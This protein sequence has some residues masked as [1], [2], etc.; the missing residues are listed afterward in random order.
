MWTFNR[1]VRTNRLLL[2]WRFLLRTSLF[3]KC[4]LMVCISN[5]INPYVKIHV[6]EAFAPSISSS[7]RTSSS[8]SY[9]IKLSA[10]AKSKE[11]YN[12]TGSG[13]TCPTWKWGSALGTAHEAAKICRKKYDTSER[14]AEL[15]KSLLL[16][17]EEDQD[18]EEDTTT[19]AGTEIDDHK[20][21]PLREPNSLE[22]VKLILALFW[23]KRRKKGYGGIEAYGQL[24]D[25]MAQGTRYEDD[26]DD[27]MSYRMLIQDMQKR[28]MFLYDTPAEDRVMLNTIWYECEPDT[29]LAFRRVSGLI[30]KNM[31]FVEMGL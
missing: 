3:S 12:I 28:F 15:I 6:A 26:E 24:V 7:F 2:F 9:N 22:E 20:K 14:R 10:T 4:F 17:D 5:S 11:V 1:Q 25:L 29:D 21:N 13:W 8:M 23:Q 27:D 30:L 18:E 16:L 31:E 19:N